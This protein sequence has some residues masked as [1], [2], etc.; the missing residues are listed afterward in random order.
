MNEK[1]VS[2]SWNWSGRATSPSVSPVNASSIS[3][4]IGSGCH[5]SPDAWSDKQ[6]TSCSRS[7][8]MPTVE[9]PM[10]YRR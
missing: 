5:S 3:S 7:P 2:L 1:S 9:R 4:D 8:D 10:G 6:S